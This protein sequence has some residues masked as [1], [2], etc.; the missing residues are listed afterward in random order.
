MKTALYDVLNALSNLKFEPTAISHQ[1]NNG[2]TALHIA[3]RYFHLGS[4]EVKCAKIPLA[5][6]FF[7]IASDLVEHGADVTIK[8]KKGEAPTDYLPDIKYLMK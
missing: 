1:D 6:F 2:D 5:K 8:N 4:I 3:C 7:R